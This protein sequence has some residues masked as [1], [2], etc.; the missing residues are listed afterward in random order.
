MYVS[1]FNITRLD[2]STSDL[3][4]YLRLMNKSND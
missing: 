2:I 3:C 1:G 4:I